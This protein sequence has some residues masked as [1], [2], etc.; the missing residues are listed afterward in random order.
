[1]N[2]D[3]SDVTIICYQGKFQLKAH[4]VILASASRH[5]R[6]VLK[7]TNEI[8]LPDVTES[9]LQTIIDYIYK[10][11]VQLQNSSRFFELSNQLQLDLA[12]PYQKFKSDLQIE[13]D[14]SKI[15]KTEL[16]LESLP[17]EILTKILSF[18][19]TCHL[20][21][22]VALTSKQFYILSNLIGT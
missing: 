18:V 11:E 17:N 10:G 3:F 7:T 19:P 22:S 16:T 6:Q 4:K 5:L 13:G 21:L 9:E 8:F 20:L 1:M 12:T 2:N 14:Q 15:V